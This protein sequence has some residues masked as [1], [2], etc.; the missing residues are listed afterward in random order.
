MHFPPQNPSWSLTG[1][2]AALR[3]LDVLFLLL[4]AEHTGVFT[5][6][7]H[8][9]MH[10]DV[11]V[12]LSVMFS[13]TNVTHFFLESLYKTLI[14]LG[15]SPQ[16]VSLRDQD[17]KAF[18]LFTSVFPAPGTGPDTQWVL[19]KY[20]W[21]GRIDGWVDRWMSGQVDRWVDQWISAP[22]DGWVGG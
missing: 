20:L 10:Y 2:E 5:L 9:A 16:E 4:G 21:D 6:K 15:C 8:R 19:S 11:C 1:T 12:F 14:L 13:H 3:G 22:M 18:V 17:G 7:T